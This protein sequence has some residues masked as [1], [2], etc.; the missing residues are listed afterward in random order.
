MWRRE[1]SVCDWLQCIHLFYARQIAWGLSPALGRVAS[2]AGLVNCP[3]YGGIALTIWLWRG[4]TTT[5]E[6]CTASKGGKAWCGSDTKD[7]EDLSDKAQLWPVPVSIIP[8]IIFAGFILF[9]QTNG[10][11]AIKYFEAILVAGIFMQ[12]WVKKLHENNSVS[13]E[14]LL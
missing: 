8:K 4:P 6:Y 11:V 2:L 10:N 9:A 12:V 13:S 14:Y 1:V 3:G 5:P 7:H